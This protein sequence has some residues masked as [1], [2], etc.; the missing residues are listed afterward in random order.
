MDLNQFM[1]T[2]T[3]TLI[4][5]FRD[6][7]TPD[8]GA[9]VWFPSKT[10][11]D[12]QVSIAVQRM[13]AA[14][15]VDVL[16]GTGG[17]LNKFSDY[18]Q[19]NY[20]PPYFEEYFD[21]TSLRKYDIVFGAISRG[22]LPGITV[23]TDF[24]E[25]GLEESQVLKDKI[26]R[27]K[28]IQRWQVLTTGIVTMK[29]G[30]NI[31]FKRKA[32]SIVQKTSTGTWDN[33]LATPFTDVQ[34]G[35]VFLRQEGRSTGNVVDM[36]MGSNAWTNF[37]NNPQVQAQ[38]KFFNQIQRIDIGMPQYD[39]VTGFIYQ[40]RIGVGDYMVDM[41][42]YPGYF[43]NVDDTHSTYLGVDTVV[44]QARDFVGVHAH[45]GVPAIV[46]VPGVPNQFVAPFGGEYY[47][48]DYVDTKAKSWNFEVSSAPVP[49]PISVDRTYTIQTR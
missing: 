2:T 6:A 43:D 44:L 14:V 31:D 39:A 37:I 49:V 4:G 26:A 25:S 15:A 48:R 5:F 38:A 41:W 7:V 24:L 9:A 46:N 13:R 29:N 47:I 18:N 21:Y 16:R 28:E 8:Y 23:M 42:T 12:K 19:K 17:N 1:P 3:Q 30:D 33:A 45:A 32:A 11:T 20:V 10:T 22:E 36:I 34:T 40:G 27:A 35:C